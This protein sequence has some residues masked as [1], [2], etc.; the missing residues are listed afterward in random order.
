MIVVDASLATKWICSEAETPLALDFLLSFGKELCAPD[1]VFTEVGAAIV[2]R[3]N[4]RKSLADDALIALDKWTASWS[5]HVIR[6]H[7][8]TQNRLFRAGK[9][10]IEIGHP[11]K[12]CIYLALAVELDC[13]L[14]TCDRKF[15]AKISGRW[16]F[17]KL[18][19]DFDVQND[20]HRRMFANQPKPSAAL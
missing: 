9:I 4:E 14:A 12:D 19:E 11:I 13:I 18:L 8:V 15:A 5:D 3:A 1:T 17:I 20:F 2:R 7:R 6:P 16:G 10:A